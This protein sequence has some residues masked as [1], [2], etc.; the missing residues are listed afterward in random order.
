MVSVGGMTKTARD[1][2]DI[3]SLL[4][5]KT[6]DEKELNAGWKQLKIGFLKGSEWTSPPGYTV[7]DDRL[8]KVKDREYAVCLRKIQEA[9]ATVTDV[10]LPPGSEL[11]KGTCASPND[12][13]M[14]HLRDDINRYLENFEPVNTLDDL[15]AA[16]KA[17]AHYALPV[18]APG[19]DSL[20]ELVT[21][22]WPSD[23]PGESS[24]E[25]LD[26]VFARG[27]QAFKDLGVDVVLACGEM[28]LKSFASI[29]GLPVSALPVCGTD[30]EFN[31][32][33]VGMMAAAMPG[34]EDLLLRVAMAWNES[35]PNA[36]EPPRMMRNVS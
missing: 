17:H 23:K 9:G 7:P 16:N 18:E 11:V 12:L 27:Q 36:V 2:V 5:S 13:S 20:V 35:F 30:D 4:M 1:L 10:K 19:Q 21:Y 29:A 25:T 31:G 32:R 28:H 26:I 24:D 3:T 6:F 14:A 22:R 15:I 33:R 34:R 8:N